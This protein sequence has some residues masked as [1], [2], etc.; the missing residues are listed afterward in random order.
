MVEAPVFAQ[1]EGLREGRRHA[2]KVSTDT[3]R[4]TIASAVQA[5]VAELVDATDLNRRLSA[6][7]EIRDVELLK[8]GEPCQMAIPSQALIRGKV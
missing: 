6:P 3:T 7:G 1:T 5:G 2:S 8:F 4:P